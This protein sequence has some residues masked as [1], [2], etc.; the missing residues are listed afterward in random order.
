MEFLTDKEWWKAAATRMIRTIAQG[1][2]A[3]I[4]T[5]ATMIHEVDWKIVLSTAAF[6]GFTS[7]L[8]SIAFGLPE[9]KGDEE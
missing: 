1:A 6:A 4:G 3:G 8:T 2:L 5:S 7:I 9:R